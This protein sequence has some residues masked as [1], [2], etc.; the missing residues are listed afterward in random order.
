MLVIRLC[1]PHALF[2]SLHTISLPPNHHPRARLYS[3]PSATSDSPTLRRGN[4]SYNPRRHLFSALQ[5]SSTFHYWPLSASCGRIHSPPHSSL[6]HI[7]RRCL[8]RNHPCSSRYLSSMR[9]S[10]FLA[11]KQC[12][13]PIE[14]SNSL[15]HADFHRQLRSDHRHSTVSKQLG[16]K[17]LRWTW[18][19]MCLSAGEYMCGFPAVVGAQT[20]K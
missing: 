13:W 2:T 12:L 15:R 3:R 17:I 8:R 5:T 16:T 7:S 6:S 1:I 19:C 9:Y 20:R 14:T 10:T 11:S 4:F 18:R